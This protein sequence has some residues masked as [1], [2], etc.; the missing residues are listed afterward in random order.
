M[1]GAVHACLMRCK[2]AS[3]LGPRLIAIKMT[4]SYN[5][6]LL[7]EVAASNAT[8]FK[9]EPEFPA[10]R[11]IF[12]K[13]LVTLAKISLR[14]EPALA[15]GQPA[16]RRFARFLLCIDNGG[17]HRSSCEIHFLL[18]LICYFDKRLFE[19]VLWFDLEGRSKLLFEK[20]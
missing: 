13:P 12:H 20:E 10:R 17:N 6:D 8:R 16:T 19:N 11:S 15:K 3:T 14:R 5:W 2:H 1:L 4:R 9:R 18:R 7:G